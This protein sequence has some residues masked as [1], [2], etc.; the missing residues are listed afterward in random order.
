[1][2]LEARV[3]HL[4]AA[5]EGFQDAVYRQC[6]LEGRCIAELG[7]ADRAPRDGSCP[8]QGRTQARRLMLSLRRINELRVGRSPCQGG[9]CWCASETSG[10]E[11]SGREEQSTEQVG[12]LFY[13]LASQ[14]AACRRCL[15]HRARQR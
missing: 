2:T 8:Q 12:R 1:M 15:D 3:E 11:V 9:G 10:W 14:A 13:S 7:P 4:E 6:V 5:L